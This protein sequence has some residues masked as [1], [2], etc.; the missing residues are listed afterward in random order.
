MSVL[1]QPME[2][3]N[4]INLNCLENSEHMVAIVTM[5]GGYNG[6]TVTL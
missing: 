1:R 3:T 6:E 4:M 2:Q 5:S